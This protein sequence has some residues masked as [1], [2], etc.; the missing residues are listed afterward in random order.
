MKLCFLC[1]ADSN[2]AQLNHDRF[3]FWRPTSQLFALNVCLRDAFA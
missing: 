2:R 1:A 3:E